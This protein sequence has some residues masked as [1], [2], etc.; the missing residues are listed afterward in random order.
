MRW[1]RRGEWGPEI[2]GGPSLR[3]EQ[4]APLDAEIY[5]TQLEAVEGILDELTGFMEFFRA[6]VD[7]TPLTG[8][9]D[10]QLAVTQDVET[11]SFGRPLLRV[12]FYASGPV[13]K[14]SPDAFERLAKATAALVDGL[15]AEG[16][17]VEQIRWT[18]M[19]YLT[20]PF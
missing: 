14:S 9:T 8:V 18:E 5:S 15:N 19:P 7:G 10:G 3:D 20:R 4:W 1:T 2:F 13:G 6:E 17:Q 16:I 12:R 11:G